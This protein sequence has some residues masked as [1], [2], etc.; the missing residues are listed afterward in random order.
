MGLPVTVLAVARVVGGACSPRIAASTC[1]IEMRSVNAKS[2]SENIGHF[3]E[4]W[5]NEDRC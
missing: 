5:E 4:Q 2:G 3:D 1:R